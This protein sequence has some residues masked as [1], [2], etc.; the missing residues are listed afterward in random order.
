MKV[1]VTRKTQVKNHF[2]LISLK[3]NLWSLTIL[4]A[5]ES[6]DFVRSRG[7]RMAEGGRERGCKQSDCSGNQ[8]S[9]TYSIIHLH[10]LC[11]ESDS[12]VYTPEKNL[13]HVHQE[14]SVRM[15]STVHNSNNL[16][17]VQ[18]SIHEEQSNKPCDVFTAQSKV[19]MVLHTPGRNFNKIIIQWKPSMLQSMGC[20]ESDR[21]E[22]L[23]NN[24]NNS[25]KGATLV[26]Q[27]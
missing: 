21:T 23:N 17:T 26:A 10:T 1:R 4:R 19:T 8:L 5:G 3:N 15:F 22:W 11:P 16:Q 2:T 24:N 9:I 13:E 14:T 12:W 27:C 25:V 7:R 20:K 18:M 6:I